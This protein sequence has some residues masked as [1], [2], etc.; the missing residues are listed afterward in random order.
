M[1]FFFLK[2]FCILL[3]LFIFFLFLLVKIYS[4]FFNNFGGKYVDFMLKI[5]FGGV[6]K[7]LFLCILKY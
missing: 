3:V 2:N 6:L 4:D 1:V 7:I 5:G